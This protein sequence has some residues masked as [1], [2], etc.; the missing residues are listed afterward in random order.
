[1]SRKFAGTLFL[2]LSTAALLAQDA[3]ESYEAGIESFRRGGFRAAADAMARA[4]EAEPREQKRLR[5]SGTHFIEPY[6]PHYVLGISLY[7]LHENAHARA[8]LQLSLAAGV[9]T[10]YPEYR[11]LLLA[12][13][14]ELARQETTAPPPRKTSVSTESKEASASA[15]PPAPVT[16][17]APAVLVATPVPGASA[18]ELRLVLRRGVAEFFLCR[19]A[20][21]VATLA[22]SARAG[23]E[24]ARLFSAYALSGTYLARGSKDGAALRRARGLWRSLP[25]RTRTAPHPGISPR[26]RLLLAAPEPAH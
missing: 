13:L 10:G 25:A 6:V 14:A 22:P 19:Y 12:A 5:G 15:P 8:E 16:L 21:S 1:M 24:T 4:I 11:E 23:N 20:E 9:V 7:R 18:A 17:A 2:L 3:V 26:I